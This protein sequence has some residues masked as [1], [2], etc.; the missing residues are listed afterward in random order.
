MMH[1]S[2]KE[3]GFTLI[4]LSVVV[5]V[6]GIICAATTGIVARIYRSG[7]VAQRYVDDVVQCRRACARLESDLRLGGRVTNTN[8]VVRI[9]QP[10]V[11]VDYS[12]K[13]GV[14][15][16]G[17]G[18][19]RRVIARNIA[20]LHVQQSGDLARVR[21]ALQRRGPRHVPEAAIHKTVHLRNGAVR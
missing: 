20:A 19:T 8:G 9:H 21:I 12:L 15:S 10:A 18:G 5:A 3:R 4:E 7:E 6:L 17:V 14:L 2:A 11:T 1:S 16:R 13:D